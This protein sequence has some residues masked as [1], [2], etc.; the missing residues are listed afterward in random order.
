MEPG[1]GGLVAIVHGQ[2]RR[3]ITVMNRAVIGDGSVDREMAVAS[4]PLD[5]KRQNG[6]ANGVNV[7]ESF[8]IEE[9]AEVVECL[10]GRELV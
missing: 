1:G 3:I 9:Q 4:S 10:V 8:A 6:V 2:E 7:L 5:P